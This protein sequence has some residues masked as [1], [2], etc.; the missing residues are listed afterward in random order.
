[1]RPGAPGR[2]QL[3]GL[4]AEQAAGAIRDQKLRTNANGASLALDTE[5]PLPD[6]L[7]VLGAYGRC[8]DEL[9]SE[10]LGNDV[11]HLVPG[12]RLPGV[13][14][15]TEQQRM[16]P[17]GTHALAKE[18]EAIA[19]E[20]A[21]GQDPKVVLDRLNDL[22]A[23][24]S[25]RCRPQPLF[26]AKLREHRF[27]LVADLIDPVEAERSYVRDKGQLFVVVVRNEPRPAGDA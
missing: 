1:M 15:R 5:L 23:A 4:K 14:R 6:Y 22:A 18:V 16:L 19:L 21:I 26:L 17:D 12:V 25:A 13:Q 24:K 2:R 8:H 27:V 9:A 3:I 20:L 11:Q 7:T 10:V